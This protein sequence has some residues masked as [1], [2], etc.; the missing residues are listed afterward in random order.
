MNKPTSTRVTE[1][2]PKV[3]S[4]SEASS[5]REGDGCTRDC[6]KGRSSSPTHEEDPLLPSSPKTP[7]RASSPLQPSPTAKPPSSSLSIST[8]PARSRQNLAD[9]MKLASQTSS[10]ITHSPTSRRPL[11]SSTHVKLL[12]SGKSPANSV[13]N[14]SAKELAQRTVPENK[15][16]EKRTS[17]VDSSSGT[18]IV[19][20]L[21]RL[22]ARELTQ[23]TEPEQRLRT[24]ESRRTK[25]KAPVTPTSRAP[26]LHQFKSFVVESPTKSPRYMTHCLQEFYS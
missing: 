13:R 21:Y 19:S 26:Q 9:R 5:G 20:R 10:L 15:A 18:D 6:G 3:S 11:I 17:D 8:P 12:H 23:H 24:R 25:G 2:D 7:K 1:G 4:H 22:S 14:L 16:L